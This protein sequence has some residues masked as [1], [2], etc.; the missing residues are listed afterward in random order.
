MTQ[1]LN[2]SRTL[3]AAARFHVPF[4]HGAWWS[5][6]STLLGGLAVAL[7]RG[8]DPF[9]CVAL[10]ACLTAGFVAQDWA[11]A[12]FAAILGR[13]SQAVSQWRAWQGWALAAASV[14]SAGLVLWRAEESSR[15]AWILLLAALG[16]AVKLAL[17]SRVLQPARGRR[18]LAVT[19]LL[20]ATPALPLGVLAF[21]WER[22]ALFLWIWPLLYYPAATL[23][24]QSFIRGFPA[25]ARWLG[26]ALAAALAG[27]AAGGGAWIAA[28]LLLLQALNLHGA[29]QR[30]WI[31]Q[32]EGLPSGPAIRAFG[33]EQAFF[34]VAL[35]LLWA[36]AFGGVL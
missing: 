11:Q 20:L 4:E 33:K 9:A 34:G 35:T 36:L 32:P 5:F 6:F 17:F 27:L 26:P 10:A 1:T 31:L 14:A 30:R 19:A 21:G 22:Q 2:P 13:P 24:A 12:G 3:P 18:S 23:S 16:L 8:G 7:L 25:R 29:I 15:W 28:G